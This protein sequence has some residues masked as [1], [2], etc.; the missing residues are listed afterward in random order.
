LK[1]HAGASRVAQVFARTGFMAAG[2]VT[3]ARRRSI[4]SGLRLSVYVAIVLTLGCRRVGRLRS[5]AAS[6]GFGHRLGRFLERLRGGSAIVGQAGEKLDLSLG[7][8]QKLIAVLEVLDP[9]LVPAQRLGQAKLAFFEIVDDGF[10]LGERTLEIHV[11]ARRCRVH[12]F[13]DGQSQDPS[14]RG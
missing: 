13:I 1:S 14:F 9:L 3:S 6:S 12:W 2:K 8:F 7:R 11:L 4:V 10:E 5:T